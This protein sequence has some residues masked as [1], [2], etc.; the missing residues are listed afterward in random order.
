MNTDL[1]PDTSLWWGYEKIQ[2]PFMCLL[3]LRAE[4]VNCFTEILITVFKHRV[5]R[6]DRFPYRLNQS[7]KRFSFEIKI[8]NFLWNL[9]YLV[10]IMYFQI[11]ILIVIFKGRGVIKFLLHV[12]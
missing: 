12:Q 1:T 9:I 3:R 2:S 10:K 8:N 7:S 4:L 11:K 5:F 6:Y